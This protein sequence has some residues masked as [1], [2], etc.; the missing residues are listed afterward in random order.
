M[1]FFRMLAFSL[2][3]GSSAVHAQS[4]EMRRPSV[5]TG[6]TVQIIGGQPANPN[7]WPATLW[8]EGGAGFCTSTVVG[9]RVVLTAAHCV[10]NGATGNVRI[11][12]AS[13]SVTC[14]HHPGYVNDYRLD[15]ALCL[16]AGEIT[17]PNDAPY[18]TLNVD[19]LRPPRSSSVTLLGYGC[20][21]T[22]GGGPSRALYSGTSD[23]Q[24]Q[25]DDTPYVITSGG[26][27]VCFGDSGGGAYLSPGTG[28]RR[29][30]GVN[31]RGDIITRSLL[32]AVAH[33]AIFRFLR[34]WS[35]EKNAR[36]CGLD[37]SLLA[38]RA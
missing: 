28:S 38:C 12:N 26:A 9:P 11:G 14:D 25:A 18:E 17:L 2:L 6:S 20:R 4:F 8:F 10:D 36:I 29:L 13:T 19:P 30:F 1:H 35:L 21:R 16:A 24:S 5:S 37:A 23:V 7:A 22:G 32:S 15:I 27:A 34:D 31:S 33:P 3:L